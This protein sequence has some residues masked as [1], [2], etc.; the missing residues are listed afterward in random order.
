MYSKTNAQQVILLLLNGK[1][2]VVYI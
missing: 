2:V 1:Q